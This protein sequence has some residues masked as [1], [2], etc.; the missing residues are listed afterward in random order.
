[1]KVTEFAHQCAESVLRG[2][3]IDQSKAIDPEIIAANMGIKV[4]YLPLKGKTTS[5]LDASCLDDPTIYINSKRFKNEQRFSL[6]HQLGHYYELVIHNK[7]GTCFI[8]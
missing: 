2:Y 5:M 4:I 1:M 8:C 7:P 6:A 3:R